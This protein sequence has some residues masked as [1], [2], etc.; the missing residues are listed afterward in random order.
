MVVKVIPGEEV[1]LH[2]PLLV[3]DMQIDMPHQIKHKFTQR[4]KVWKLRDPQA[5]SRFHEV[6]KAYVPPVETEA[7]TTTEEYGR[8]SRQV[9]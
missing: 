9:C 5:C 4:P 3:C 8:I 7:A 2:H 1:A 6:F